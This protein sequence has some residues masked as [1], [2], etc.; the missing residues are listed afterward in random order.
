MCIR[1]RSDNL[2]GLADYV[3]ARTNLDVMSS[4]QVTAL[5]ASI[6]LASLGAVDQTAVDASVAS[7]IASLVGTSPETLNTLQE[8][9]A[10]IEADNTEFA[11]LTTMVSNKVGFATAQTLTPTQRLQAC[12]NIGVG[13]PDYDYLAAYVAARD[14]V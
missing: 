3:A 5:V 4:A 6:T 9:A 10:E 2:S 1:D 7:G 8:I 12:Q 11:A 14:A 13:N